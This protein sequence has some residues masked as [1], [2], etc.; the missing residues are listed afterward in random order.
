M[1]PHSEEAKR[2][3][4]VANKGYRHTKEA[5]QKISEAGKGRVPWNKGKKC[6]HS[7]EIKRKISEAN[8]GKPSPFKGK[9]LSKEHKIKV[10]EG[11]KA[12]HKKR[13]EQEKLNR[14]KES[15]K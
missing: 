11:M 9:K 13:R 7:E 8:K 1:G 6:P 14:Y 5:K 10:S 2:K 4:S 15:C 3:I 12:F